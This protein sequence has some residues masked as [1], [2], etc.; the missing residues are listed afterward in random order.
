V[1]DLV[2]G[3]GAF[4]GFAYDAGAAEAARVL[5]V[6]DEVDGM[7]AGPEHAKVHGDV[8]GF[9]EDGLEGGDLDAGGKN[10]FEVFHGEGPTEGFL[11]EELV[12][13]LRLLEETRV[14]GLLHEGLVPFALAVER[15][16]FVVEDT[17]AGAGLFGLVVEG[18]EAEAERDG[19]D[20]EDAEGDA[21]AANGWAGIGEWA[22]GE[23]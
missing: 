22:G 1:V 18:V 23:I 21:K 3:G 17:L 15:S 16:D 20:S 19:Y 11:I 12:E 5:E 13:G 4:R 9:V 6:A 14:V 10:G 7:V 2:A 8:V